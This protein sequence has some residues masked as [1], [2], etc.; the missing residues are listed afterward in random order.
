MTPLSQ[1]SQTSLHSSEIDLFFDPFILVAHNVPRPYQYSQW[2]QNYIAVYAKIGTTYG[3]QAGSINEQGI[4]ARDFGKLD[5]ML[6]PKRVM[7]S[8][9]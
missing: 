3:R 9:L 4:P 6:A 8:A 1:K 7:T 2:I 5:T